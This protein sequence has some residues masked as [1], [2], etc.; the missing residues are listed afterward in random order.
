MPK[1]R[2]A[3]TGSVAPATGIFKKLEY[4]SFIR[5]RLLKYLSN[6]SRFHR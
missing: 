3:N 1:K 2:N 5:L 6:K 4:M